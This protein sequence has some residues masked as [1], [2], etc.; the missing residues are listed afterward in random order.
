M[1]PTLLPDDW[2]LVV[3]AH[4]RQLL[5]VVTESERAALEAIIRLNGEMKTRIEHRWAEANLPTFEHYI[6]TRL[7]ARRDGGAAAGA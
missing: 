1:A 5:A 6:R 3:D 4:D 7:A 2:V